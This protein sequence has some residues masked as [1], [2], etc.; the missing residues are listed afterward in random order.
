M[1]LAFAWVDRMQ[2]ELIQPRSGC[3]GHYFDSL[4][5]DET[6]VLPR[7]NHI[8]MR[9]DDL[10]AMR[11]EISELNLPILFEGSLYGLTFVY[12]DARPE[13]GHPRVRL[14]HRRSLAGIGLALLTS[15]PQSGWASTGR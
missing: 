12:V 10:D 9:R 5:K 7:F 13:L 11:V 14:G 8:A 6:D 1:R 3:V 15:P 2:V 4:P